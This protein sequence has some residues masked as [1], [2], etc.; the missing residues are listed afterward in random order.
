M[1][2]ALDTV[3]RIAESRLCGVTRFTPKT[4]FVKV[5]KGTRGG[6]TVTEDVAV[7]NDF[8]ILYCATSAASHA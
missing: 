5:L 8:V 1:N 7:K 4:M 2:K 6:Y 3:R